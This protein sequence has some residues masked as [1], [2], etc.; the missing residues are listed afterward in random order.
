MPLPRS[1]THQICNTYTNYKHKQTN[2]TDEIVRTGRHGCGARSIEREEKRVGRFLSLQ[3]SFWNWY[4]VGE[5]LVPVFRT[6][7][8]RY[9]ANDV[10]GHFGQAQ[11]PNMAQPS[12][13][14]SQK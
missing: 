9:W 1:K 6:L 14:L 3:K 12:Y 2:Q 4:C 13:G 8:L 5:T 11:S 10:M 7:K